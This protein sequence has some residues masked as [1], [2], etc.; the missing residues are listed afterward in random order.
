[1]DRRVEAGAE[2]VGERPVPLVRPPP[3]PLPEAVKPLPEDRVLVRGAPLPGTVAPTPPAPQVAPAP[4]APA[5]APGSAGA[6]Q[7]APQAGDAFM[8]VSS[9]QEADIYVDGALLRP[10]HGRRQA[11]PAGRHVVR[12]VAPDGRQVNKVVELGEGA[13]KVLVWDFERW[14]WR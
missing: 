11:Y 7:A 3:D 13:E 1:V 10:P 2:V 12:F 4:T 9:I 14:S 5:P 8:T 6:S